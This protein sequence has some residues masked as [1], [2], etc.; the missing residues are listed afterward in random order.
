MSDDAGQEITALPSVLQAA[1][2]TIPSGFKAKVAKV[3]LRLIAGSD[4]ALPFVAKVRERWDTM[5]G[6]SHVASEL[7]KEVAKRAI[8]DPE[9]VRRATDRFLIE[10]SRSQSNIESVARLAIEDLRDDPATVE[11]N[12]DIDEYWISK[13]VR[14]SQDASSSEAQNLWAKVLA[15]EIRQAGSFS[16][17]TMRFLSELDK[18]VAETFLELTRN[19]LHANSIFTPV[20]RWSTGPALKKLKLLLEAGLISDIPGST[21]RPVVADQNGMLFVWQERSALV[22]KANP[23]FS[24]NIPISQFTTVG[25]EIY[26]L[27]EP[28]DEFF[29]LED[30][31]TQLRSIIEPQSTYAAIGPRVMKDGGFT[32]VAPMKVLWGDLTEI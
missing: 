14:F 29:V 22:I 3:L 27:I 19:T 9:V 31:A 15:G 21:N 24:F 7:A 11:M 18:N 4:S 13:F 8:T 25:E 1:V 12:N 20:D 26:K 23:S 17:R 32:S 2:K 28:A 10:S 16:L 5:D 30:I 6:Q